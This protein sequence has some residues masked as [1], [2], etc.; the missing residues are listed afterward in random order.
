MHHDGTMY[1][2]MFIVGIE[3]PRGQAT[4]HYDID[5]YWDM[6]ECPELERAPKWDG[7]T[8]QEAI[9][10]IG[11]LTPLRVTRCKDCVCIGKRPP[12]PQ[13]YRKDAGWCM[14]HG[15]VVLPNDFCSY[16]ETQEEKQ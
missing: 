14:L 10:R 2:G 7:H 9:D 16:G 6:F 12:L 13:G 4:Y 1:N 3:T 5:P 15:H 8:P 11:K